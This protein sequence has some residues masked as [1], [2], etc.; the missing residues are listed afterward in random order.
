MPTSRK[1]LESYNRRNLLLD[2]EERFKLL[3]EDV[4][5]LDGFF[6]QRKVLIGMTK[7]DI[8]LV[9]E[10]YRIT[11]LAFQEVDDRNNPKGGKH[12]SLRG[13]EKISDR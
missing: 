9:I 13:E 11:D 5:C 8:R 3:E 10:I 12:G 6:Y 1:G 4:K 7:K 2:Y